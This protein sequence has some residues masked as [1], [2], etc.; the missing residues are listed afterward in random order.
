MSLVPPSRTAPP[1]ARETPP[2]SLAARLGEA[3]ARRGVP[4]CQWK[5]HGKRERWESGRGDIDLLVDR[6]AWPAF[7]DAL[8]GLGFKP[9]LPPPGREA[10]GIVH[11]FGLDPR[12]GSGHLVHVHAY[13]RLVL[14]LPWRTHYRVPLEEALLHSAVL[15]PGAI[16]KTP[17]PALETV[18]LVLRL[19]LRHSLADLMRPR[20][21]PRPASRWLAG[22][23]PE[24][25]R[26]EEQTSRGAVVAALGRHLPEVS[27][28]IFDR[29]RDALRAECPALRR[30]A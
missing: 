30:L 28:E 20:S 5:G 22:A 3:L 9:A 25:D 7:S 13:A 29:C 27:L 1:P 16:F 2:G 19:T 4:Y 23:L 26:L 18:L 8:G 10:P 11:F 24:L 14:G 6:A 15:Q 21:R 17:A 12:A